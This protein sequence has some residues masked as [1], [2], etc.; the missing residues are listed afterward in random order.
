MGRHGWEDRAGNGWT[1]DIKEQG[2]VSDGHIHVLSM[3]VQNRK[4]WSRVVRSARNTNGLSRMDGRMDGELN[5]PCTSV[6]SSGGI[7]LRSD[8]YGTFT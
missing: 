3:M 7:K 2:L 4:Q 1:D 5:M 8:A 6:L